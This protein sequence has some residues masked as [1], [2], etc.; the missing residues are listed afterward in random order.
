MATKREAQERVDRGDLTWGHLKQWLQTGGSRRAHDGRERGQRRADE[1]AVPEH[2]MRSRRAGGRHSRPRSGDGDPDMTTPQTDLT[3]RL[4][5]RADALM[6]E[7]RLVSNMK[8][9]ESD[10][11]FGR[12]ATLMR[13]AAAAL[14]GAETP[15]GMVVRLPDLCDSAFV[16]LVCWQQIDVRD[17]WQEP[18]PQNHQEPVYTHA[19]KD[20]HPVAR[21]DRWHRAAQ[22][23]P[24]AV[25]PPALADATRAR[26]ALQVIASD[27]CEWMTSPAD[28]CP[29]AATPLANYCHTCRARHALAAQAH[30]A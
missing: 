15:Q 28:R 25:D 2:L 14:A 10:N 27:E 3:A 12:D 18:P 21:I 8:R 29:Q 13:E 9:P 5:A 4:L 11:N 1:A 23:P 20:G 30:H 7:A 24:P 16:C 19:A 22:P 6:A 17:V 26:E